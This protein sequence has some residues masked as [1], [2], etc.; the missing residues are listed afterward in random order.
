MLMTAYL[1][2]QNLTE[3]ELSLY[4]GAGAVS[5]LAAIDIVP[6]VPHLRYISCCVQRCAV[7]VHRRPDMSMMPDMHCLALLHDTCCFSLD[8]QL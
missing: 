7:D 6:R 8:V 4:R 5:G 2:W 1:K 3:A